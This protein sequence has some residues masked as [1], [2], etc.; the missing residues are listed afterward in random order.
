MNQTVQFL[1]QHGYLL[2]FCWL[3]AEQAA[4]PVP[5]VPL[6]LACGAL[7]RAGRMHPALIL[8]YGLS[9][10]LLADSVWFQLGRRRGAKAVRFLCRMSLEPDSCV[11]QTKNAFQKYGL[12]SL[13]V[14]KFVPGLNAVS[15][16]LAGSSGAGFGRFLGMDALGVTLWLAF[17]TGLGYLFSNQ[18]EAV[19][20][21]AMRTGLG[22]TLVI[23][24]ILAGWI[25]WKFAQRSR[26]LRKL[27]VARIT[28][29]Q[30]RAQLR[31]GADP[32]LVDLRH[33]LESGFEPIP[34]ALRIVAEELE[35]RAQEIPR[36]RDI[37]LF[38]S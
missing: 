38:C 2:L 13:L 5:S 31:G 17:Y 34:G 23:V 30:L 4:L 16:P 32:L 7:L 29:E 27:A 14:S 12:R 9:A 22:V 33:A 35:Q 19:A 11:R 25:V 1:T 37:I 20:V 21:H 10:C 15:A 36:D 6:L 3:A 18:L 26:F 24:G 8:L 28:A